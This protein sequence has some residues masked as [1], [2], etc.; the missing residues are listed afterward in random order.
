MCAFSLEISVFVRRKTYLET[1]EQIVKAPG[2]D[3][4]I[5]EGHE[6]GHD[7]GGDT[8]TTQPWMNG[9]PYA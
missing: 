1:I 9:V 2:D 8:D 7:T 6:K 4:V 5:V 3:N